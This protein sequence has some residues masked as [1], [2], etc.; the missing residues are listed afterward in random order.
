MIIDEYEIKEDGKSV[1][2]NTYIKRLFD[3]IDGIMARFP[4]KYN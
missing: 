3:E 1:P 2:A 4:I